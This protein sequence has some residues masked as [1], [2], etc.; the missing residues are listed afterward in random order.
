M[1]NYKVLLNGRGGYY[2]CS[3]INTSIA[4]F[5]LNNKGQDLLEEYIFSQYDQDEDIN[6]EW[7]IPE[8]YR[9]DIFNNYN[10]ICLWETD[11]IVLNNSTICDI[12]ELDNEKKDYCTFN[13]E[14]DFKN[15]KLVDTFLCSDNLLIHRKQDSWVNLIKKV[16]D[17]KKYIEAY[18]IYFK[19][20]ARGHATHEG[21]LNLD[22]PFDIKKFKF[23]ASNLGEEH[24]E[25]N[26][27]KK[28]LY[29]PDTY[30]EKVL[31]DFK[32]LDSARESTDFSQVGYQKVNINDEFLKLSW[33]K[34]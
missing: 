25:N 33:I 16:L 26:I 3:L 34:K 1:I 9:F 18:I 27:I 13:R 6:D 30:N 2:F 28:A 11:S 32:M 23:F 10:S 22:R 8:K 21:V 24:E 15:Q 14:S 7:R 17:D 4:E 29:E 31:Y 5:W 19:N 12:Y 20:N